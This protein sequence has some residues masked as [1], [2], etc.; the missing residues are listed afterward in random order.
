MKS[1]ITPKEKIDI[2]AGANETLHV[3]NLET[4]SFTRNI[5]PIC[6]PLLSTTL[7]LL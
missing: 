2:K 3:V 5:E 6:P 7:V 1:T 4:H